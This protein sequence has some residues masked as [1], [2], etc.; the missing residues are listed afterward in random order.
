MKTQIATAIVN[1]LS[2]L[3]SIKSVSFDRVRML[4][5][6]FQDWEIPAIQIIDLGDDNEH[7]QRRALKRWNV[8]IELVMGSKSTGLIF[9]KDLWNLEQ[10]IERKLWEVPNLA[11]PSVVH[12][13]LLGSTTDLH[14]LAP[15]YTARIDL[16]I[17]YYQPLVDV[18]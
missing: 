16:I 17:E 5:S 8:T 4:S 2:T 11:I 6:D 7:A 9:Q 3:T 10:E 12:M 14:T 15:Y 1:K 18:C 13:H